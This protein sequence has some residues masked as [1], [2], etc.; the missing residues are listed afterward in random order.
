MHTRITG[1]EMKNKTLILIDGHALCFRMFFAL[2]RTN[3]QTTDHTPTWAIY[4]FF[5][6]IFDMLNNKGLIQP[7]NIAVAFDVSRHTFRLEQYEGYKANRETMP[8]ALR[9]QLSLIMEGLKALNIPIYTKEG[10]EGDDII[11]TISKKAKELGHKTYILTGDKDSLQLVDKEGFIKVL[12][13][14]KGELVEYDWDMVYEK[15]G[16]YPNQVIDY[17]ALCGDTSDNIPGV[18]GIGPKTACDLLSNYKTLV[19]VYEH[20]GEITKKS[21]VEKLTNDKETAF[22]SQF[23]ATIKRDVDI[24]FNFDSTCLEIENREDI[25]NYFKKLQFYNFL[26]NIDRLL[27]PFVCRNEAQ[28]TLSFNEEENI[29][30]FSENEFTQTSL[31]GSIKPQNKKNEISKREEIDFKEFNP[32]NKFAFLIKDDFCYFADDKFFTKTSLNSAEKILKDENLEKITYDIKS[33]LHILPNIKNVKEDIMLTSYV[34]DSSRK[35]DLIS[36]AQNYLDIL[37]EDE[38]T[39]TCAIYDLSKCYENKL[40]DKEK[41]LC[42]L[43]VKLAEVLYKMEKTGVTLDLIYMQVLK[44]EIDIKIKEYEEKIYNEAGVK[45]NINSPKQVAD[46]LFNVLQIKPKKKNKTGYSTNAKILEE[47]AESNQIAKDILEHRTYMKLKT[48]YVDSLPKLVDKN[49]KIHTH[50]NQTVTTTGRLSSSDPNLQ[51]IPIKTDFSNRI[52]AAFVASDKENYSILSADYSQIELRLLA[53]ISGDK[54]LIEAFK[55]N[56]DV[57]TLTASKIFGVEPNSVTKEMRRKAKAVNFGIIYGQTR[58]GLSSALGITPFEAQDFIDRYFRQYPKISQYMTNTLMEAHDA[59]YVETLFGRRRYLNEELNSRNAKI[60][61]F[62]ERAAIN[63]PLQGTSADLI[64]M[65]MVELDERLKNYRANIL[66][67]VHDEL[68]LEVH[69]DDIEPVSKIVLESMELGQ[70]LNVPLEVGM[71]VGKSWMETK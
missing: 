8:D 32:R 2:E 11:G 4:G 65:A 24:D 42:N 39:L 55:S 56:V 18:K 36:Q 57:H 44:N 59:G 7:D 34:L 67:Q 30:K 16:V 22:L 70:P 13:P 61:E 21:V 60:R 64:K 51:N 12:I 23:L 10:F 5:K 31:F 40:T 27:K 3:M 19:G 25:I 50:Y 20:I 69:N 9:P 58:Y 28:T 15:M 29:V 33:E 66:I 6:A 14:S 52:R 54:A 41:K 17:K 68:V 53:H 26:K 46:V 45:F 1:I 71:K 62:A 37:D 47:L 43:E 49:N 38:K 63:A 48:T 35:H